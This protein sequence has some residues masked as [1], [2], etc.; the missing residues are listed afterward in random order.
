ML[1]KVLT[2]GFMLFLIKASSQNVVI[3]NNKN[4]NEQQF[5]ATDSIWGTEIKDTYRWLENTSSP[6]TLKWLN[7]QDSLREKYNGKK[8]KSLTEKL[9]RYSTVY[10]KPIFKEGNYFFSYHYNIG[11]SPSLYYNKSGFFSQD[12]FLFDPNPLDKSAIMSIDEIKLSSDNKTLAMLISKNG[13]DWKTARFLDLKT[14]KLLEDTINFIKYSHIYWYNNGIFYSK[15]EVNDIKESFSNVIIGQALYYHRIGTNQKNDLLVFKPTNQYDNFS[16]LV[17]PEKKYLIIERSDSACTRVSISVLNSNFIFENKDFIIT[18]K[19]EIYF[20]ILGELNGKILV[21]SNLSTPNGAIYQFFPNEINQGEIF[22]PQGT[23]QLKS[24]V[25]IDNKLLSIFNDGKK[26][27]ATVHDSISQLLYRWFIPEGYEFSYVSGSIDDPIAVYYF[28]S[29]FSP[30]SIYKINL[31][32]FENIPVD[33]TFVNFNNENIATEKVYYYSKDST[34]VPMYLTYKKGLK[35]NGNN[36]TILYG[37]GGF[38]ISMEPFFKPAN[39]IFFNNGGILATPCLRG[40]G[41]FPKWHEKGMRLNKQNTFDDFIYAAEYLIEKKYT[42]SSKLAAMGGSHG[43]LVVGACMVQRPELFH[44]VVASAGVFDMIRY[45][46]FNIGYRY[47]SEIGNVTDSLDFENL[48]KYS[49]VH[50]VKKGVD[51]PATLLIASDNDD[52]VLPFHSFKFLA[53]LQEKGSGKNPYILYYQKRSGHSG[54]DN[55]EEMVKKNAYEYSFI[56]K[57]LGVE[58]KL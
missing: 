27:F 15:Y 32:T 42:N 13:S 1:K 48:I 7:T 50:N 29:F 30:P 11:A 54:N 45:H 18:K 3:N 56:F 57:H 44:V 10:I 4:N 33:S 39:I 24:S 51:Y 9:K 41:E 12:R 28:H 2:F 17:T 26:S 52:R 25:I 21:R 8:L 16:F 36:P 35:L 55:F 31:K 19:K 43:G 38:G 46:L 20:D 22:L 6:L 14:K 58:N 53:E 40:G 23:Q 5:A 47:K 37:Y 49:P 34:I